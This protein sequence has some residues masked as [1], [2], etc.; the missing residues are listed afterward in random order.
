V[1]SAQ[2]ISEETGK[3]NERHDEYLNI[4]HVGNLDSMLAR[5]ENCCHYEP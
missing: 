2:I 4:C 5:R 3:S 1:K